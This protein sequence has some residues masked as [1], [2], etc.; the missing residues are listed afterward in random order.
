MTERHT[1]PKFVRASELYCV[2]TGTAYRHP[3]QQ[4]TDS[5]I[6]AIFSETESDPKFFDLTAP[7]PAVEQQ[8]DHDRADQGGEQR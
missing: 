4:A 2:Q 7:G 3:D 6:A 5:E 8:P 1:T